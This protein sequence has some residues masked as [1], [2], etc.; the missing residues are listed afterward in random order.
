MIN[1]LWHI[2][3][4]ADGSRHA[5]QL[6]PVAISARAAELQAADPD[7][8]EAD[9]DAEAL[10]EAVDSIRAELGFPGYGPNDGAYAHGRW[11]SRP[12][13][14][15]HVAPGEPHESLMKIATVHR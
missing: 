1:N 14:Q 13:W 9:A 7:L 10:G 3:S 15:S 2:A 8:S 11:M 5:H 6:D 4:T 12:G